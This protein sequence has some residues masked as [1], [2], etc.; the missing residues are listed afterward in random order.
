MLIVQTKYDIL[1]S[2]NKRT[3]TSSTT[4]L[5]L[6]FMRTHVAVTNYLGHPRDQISNDAI[7][8]NVNSDIVDINTSALHLPGRRHDSLVGGLGWGG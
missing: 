3:L 7:V 5:L 6:H 2:S 1:L 8:K 4:L